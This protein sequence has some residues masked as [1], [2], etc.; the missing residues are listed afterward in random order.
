[1]V[2]YFG[3]SMILATRRTFLSALLDSRPLLSSFTVGSSKDL[4]RSLSTYSI[5]ANSTRTRPTKAKLDELAQK[6]ERKRT[7][8]LSKAVKQDAKNAQAR[9][10]KIQKELELQ[11]KQQ[12][13]QVRPS[14]AGRAGST[15]GV[16][17]DV[18]RRSRRA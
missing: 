9:V 15:D 14:R 12:E 2:L 1:M 18:C 16:S 6:A 8:R 4:E 17:L 7:V 5:V 11:H 3:K 10:G 13:G